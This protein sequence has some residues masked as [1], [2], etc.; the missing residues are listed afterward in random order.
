ML[1]DA[2]R[3]D[4]A[5]ILAGTNDLGHAGFDPTLSAA[6]ILERVKQLHGICH[7]A[8]VRTVALI[9]PCPMREPFRSM[10]RELAELMKLWAASEPEVLAH[11]DVEE[12]VPRA[13][14]HL[15]DDEIHMSREGQL[16]L[17]KFLGQVLAGLLPAAQRS[18]SPSS[19][20]PPQSQR[21]AL[22][23]S[24]C[25]MQE[26]LHASPAA[27]LRVALQR[28]KVLRKVEAPASARPLQRRRVSSACAAALRVESLNRPLARQA[29]P[30]LLLAY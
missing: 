19:E 2:D 20:S 23:L 30:A 21:E 8:G 12:V 7:A 15:W 5:L 10:Q 22:R 17:G 6:E 18:T 4:V 26:Q 11:F 29:M 16:E 24:P 14:G 1:R 9:P 27:S 25:P 3:Q 28:S 13:V